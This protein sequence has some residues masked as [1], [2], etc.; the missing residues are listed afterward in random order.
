MGRPVFDGP[1]VALGAGVGV[2]GEADLDRLV[3]ESDTNSN[4]IGHRL[5]TTEDRRTT[6]A[7]EDPLLARRRLVRPEK[8][9]TAEKPK[10]RYVHRDDGRERAALGLAAL[11]AVTNPDGREFT[12]DLVAHASAQTTTGISHGVRIAGLPFDEKGRARKGEM[13]HRRC[14]SCSLAMKRSPLGASISYCTIL[15]EA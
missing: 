4:D 1:P 5:P 10:R 8:L 11:Q 15:P 6:M 2:P 3:D 7:A 14:N 13:A 12:V 9:L